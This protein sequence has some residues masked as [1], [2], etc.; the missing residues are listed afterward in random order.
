MTI[1]YKSSDAVLILYHHHTVSYVQ[2]EEISNYRVNSLLKIQPALSKAA[3]KLN[4]KT[5]YDI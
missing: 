3:L 1:T 4:K 2:I 5:E